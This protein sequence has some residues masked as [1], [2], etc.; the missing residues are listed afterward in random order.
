MAAAQRAQATSSA[1][2]TTTTP[3][4]ALAAGSAPA[5]APPAEGLNRAYVGRVFPGSPQFARPEMLKAYALA[6]NDPNPAYL[7]DSRP[8]GIVAPPIFPVRLTKEVMFKAVTDPGLNAD[9]LRLVHGEQD[10]KFFRPIRPWDLVATRATIAGVEDKS[11]GQILKVT[12]RCYEE[13]ELADQADQALF[14]R[15]SK[16]AA[17]AAGAGAGEKKGD[18]AAAA[19]SGSAGKGE[20]LFESKMKVTDDQTLRYAEA[21]GDNNPIHVDPEVAKMAGFP[22]MILQGLC[23][24]AFASRAIVLEACAGNPTRLKRFAV[25]FS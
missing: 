13:G 17:A 15:A 6:T 21:S 16:K 8:G 25:R 12:M 23:T 5:A 1:T 11:S 4:T 24:M 22:A 19:A 3:A 10:K 20:V 18:E 7:D 9:L 14:I 2:A